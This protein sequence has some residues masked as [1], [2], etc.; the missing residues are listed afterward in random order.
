MAVFSGCL[1]VTVPLC[2]PACRQ[3]ENPIAFASS[4]ETR[5]LTTGYLHAKY[6]SLLVFPLE[7]SADWSF[8]CI[9]YVEELADPRNLMTAALYAVL[10]WLSIASQPWEILVELF[11]RSRPHDKGGAPT[12]MFSLKPVRGALRAHFPLAHT[13]QRVGTIPTKRCSQREVG[14]VYCQTLVTGFNNPQ[15]SSELL[16]HLIPSDGVEVVTC[17]CQA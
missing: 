11:G 3:V 8:A 16:W 17:N 10:L 6:A 14:T 1:D 4:W 12:A 15:N 9:P 2:C 13:C 5:W 7:L